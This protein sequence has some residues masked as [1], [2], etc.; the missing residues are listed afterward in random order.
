MRIITGRY[1]GRNLFSV[2]GRTTRPT[3]AYNR[4]M[5]FSVY[6][7]YEGKRVLDLFAGTGSFGLEALS[8]GAVWVDLVEFATPAVA[9]ILKNIKLLGCGSECHVWRKRAD[10]FLKNAEDSWDVIFLDP[11]YARN[12]LNPSLDLI[13]ER[14]LLVQGGVVI[15]EH[16]PL[17]PVA[18]IYQKLIL[19]SKAG[20]TSCFTLLGTSEPGSQE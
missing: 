1:K 7:D 16:S 11:P 10:A 19:G 13:Y 18:E 20:K 5:I 17:E 2:E 6:S 14:S 15:A 12:L 9:T 8:R 4:A 3:T